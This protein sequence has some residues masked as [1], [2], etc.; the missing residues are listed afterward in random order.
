MRVLMLSKACLVGLYQRKLEA[1]AAL[2]AMNAL[3]V[4]VPPSWKDERGEMH[5]ERA[6]TQ[7]YDLEVTPIRWNGQFHLHYY[8]HLAQA[9]DDF[10]PD[11]L[12]IDEEPYNLATWLALWAAHQ[13]GIPSLFFS[14]QNILRRYPAPFR[15][16]E[17]WVL[18]HSD[19]AL[20]GTASAAQVWRAKGY[21]GPLAVIP[22]FGVDPDLFPFRPPKATSPLRIVYSGRLVAEKGLDTLLQ[23]LVQLKGEWQV[24]IIGGGPQEAALKQQTQAL[25]LDE[26]IQFVGQV[27]SLQMPHYLAQADIL[28]IPSRTMPNWK[29]QFGR[30]IIEAMACGVAVVGSDSGAIP[31]VIGAAGLIFREGDSQGLAQHLQALHDDLALR[32]R[33]AQAGRARVLECFTQDQVAAQTVAVYEA[34]LAARRP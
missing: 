29:E 33:L 15:W 24:Q 13:R 8:P 20:M 21:Q 25:H 26:R 7:G 27:P 28:V 3:K 9:L 10:Q 31:D 1:M 32:Q 19:Y 18:R 30:V 23:A 17:A 2:P 16:S 11:L 14:W 34:M 22:Q 6:Y 12:H 5:L 4:L